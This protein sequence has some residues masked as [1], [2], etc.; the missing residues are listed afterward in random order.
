MAMEDV[1]RIL[2]EAPYGV[3]A[4]SVDG[5]PRLRHMAF[6]V[7]EGKLVG[8]VSEHDLIDVSAKLLERFLAEE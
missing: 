1:W 4:T 6:V 5:Q 2:G 8:I 3:M 7:E